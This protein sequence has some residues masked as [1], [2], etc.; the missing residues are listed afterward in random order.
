LK[1]HEVIVDDKKV[2]LTATEFALLALLSQNP[3][4]V[5]TR[6]QLLD[7]IRGR[8]LTPFDRSVDI[9]ISHL[10]QKINDTAKEP[11]YIK[12]VWGVGYKFEDSARE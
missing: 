10:R 6:D 4:K 12:T 5:F 9:H 11:L 7:E 2:D 8:E 3:G 1:K